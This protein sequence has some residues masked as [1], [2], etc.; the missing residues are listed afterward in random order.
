MRGTF[1]PISDRYTDELRQ[2][3]LSM[4]RL[5][6]N[7]RPSISEIMVQPIILNALMHLYTDFGSV[8]CR[9]YLYVYLIR[10]YVISFKC[11]YIRNCVWRSFCCIIASEFPKQMF[12]RLLIHHHHI[13]FPQYNVLLG[14]IKCCMKTCPVA[15]LINSAG[16]SSYQSLCSYCSL[17]ECF[18]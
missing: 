13:V 1:A 11:D 15:Q 16:V 2:L 4:L 10:A 3:I 18:P 14:Q 5:D 7:K 9:R 17:A 6:P 8:P 12:P